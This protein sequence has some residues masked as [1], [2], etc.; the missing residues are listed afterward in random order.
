[1]INEIKGFFKQNGLEWTGDISTYKTQ[2]FHPAEEKD[3]NTL[4]IVDFL[5]TFGDQGYMAIAVELDLIRFTII[6]ECVGVGFDKYAGN[7]KRHIRNLQNRARYA[8]IN[9]L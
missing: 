8:I 6:G 4:D 2:D 9:T 5:I 1:M 3:F 7:E